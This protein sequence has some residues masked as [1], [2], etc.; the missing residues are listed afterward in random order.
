MNIIE[1][2]YKTWTLKFDNYDEFD[3]FQNLLNDSAPSATYPFASPPTH[4]YGN[5]YVTH[6]LPK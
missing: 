2:N 4:Q 6:P 3:E 1:V 5:Q